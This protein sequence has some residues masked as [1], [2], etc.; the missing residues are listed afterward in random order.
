MKQMIQELA[1]E[2]DADSVKQ[3]YLPQIEA[4]AYLKEILLDDTQ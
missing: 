4:N 2:V 1:Q 3:K